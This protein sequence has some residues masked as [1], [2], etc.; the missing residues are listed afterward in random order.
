MPATRLAARAVKAFKPRQNFPVVTRR[1]ATHYVK[2]NGKVVNAAL[3]DAQKFGKAAKKK[4]ATVRK[5]KATTRKRSASAKKAAE[6]RKANQ[7]SA[8]S[9]ELD[10]A[11]RAKKREAARLKDKLKGSTRDREQVRQQLADLRKRGAGVRKRTQDRR[12]QELRSLQGKLSAATR[13]V[14]KDQ[15]ALDAAETA[16]LKA[17][18]DFSRHFTLGR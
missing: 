10:S 4:K 16:S 12:Q 8:K 6:T 3:S 9:R 14:N 15:K 11:L 2:P 1:G 13:K 5:A 7:R 17:E 18:F